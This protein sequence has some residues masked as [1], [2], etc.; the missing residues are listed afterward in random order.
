[1]VDKVKYNG[2]VKWVSNSCV[3]KKVEVVCL[4]DVE[5]SYPQK[6]GPSLPVEGWHITLETTK[7]ELTAKAQG[8]ALLR[9]GGNT[10]LFPN[11]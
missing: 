1:M 2:G 5:C 7:P 8:C 6:E 11:P 10:E 4:S 9:M 3:R